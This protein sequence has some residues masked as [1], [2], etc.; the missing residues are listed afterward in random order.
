M[1]GSPLGESLGSDYGYKEGAS[2]GSLYGNVN[3]KSEVSPLG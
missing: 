1:E 2:N 3:S